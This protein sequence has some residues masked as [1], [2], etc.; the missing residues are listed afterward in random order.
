ME[1]S[2]WPEDLIAGLRDEGEAE[3]LR[4][5]AD[6]ME[7]LFSLDEGEADLVREVVGIIIGGQK[8]DLERFGNASAERVVALPDEAALNDYTWRVAGCVGVFWTKLGYLTMSEGFSRQPQ[9]ELL[10]HAVEYG[11]GLQL[12]N[13]LRDLPKDLRNRRCYLPVN[14]P[15]DR[16][17]LMKE[18]ERWRE[19]AQGK[20]NH[21]FAYSEKLRGKRLRLSSKLPAMIAQETLQ[22]LEG[23]SFEKLEEGYKVPRKRVYLMILGG[24]LSA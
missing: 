8:L 23:I 6:V 14:E 9:E 4:Q 22:G 2:P 20:I 24:F 7:A 13:I 21:G 3:L 19:V 17:E 10:A 15:G 16:A 18:F 12:V 5:H 11:K 1:A